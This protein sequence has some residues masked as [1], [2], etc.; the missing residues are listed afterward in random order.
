MAGML[1]IFLGENLIHH[2]HP[3]PP[4]TDINDPES[5]AK[6]LRLMPARFF[7]ALLVNY[8]INAFLAGIIAT[9]ISRRITILPAAIVGVVLTL[10]GFY[11]AIYL[12]HPAWFTVGYILLKKKKP[13]GL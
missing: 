6:G 8:A 5:L 12:P 1:L 9:L 2:L 11:N 10:A 7:V 3:L 4:G 13:A